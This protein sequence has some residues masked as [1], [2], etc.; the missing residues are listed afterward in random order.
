M[1]KLIIALL[2]VVSSPTSNSQT[3]KLGG[4]FDFMLGN[5]NLTHELG[6]D[7]NIEYLL[8][9]IP[10]SLSGCVRLHLS[11]LNDE[12]FK[13]SRG[14]T[15]NIYS[16]GI[17]VKYYPIRWDIE[18]YIGC[19]LFYNFN[20]SKASEMPYFIN[21]YLINPNIIGYNFSTEISGGLIFSA[22]NPI[23]FIFEITQSF[24]KPS[25]DLILL[26]SDN[27]KTIKKEQFNFNSFFIKL[28]VRFGL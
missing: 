17:V 11:E 2:L 9:G 6:P 14:Y 22:R 4:L 27:N 21:G 23:N 16:L 28:G 3:V 24:N 13:F 19:G 7:V 12:K 1:K 10:I 15:Y 25:Y 8:D 26:D 18:P 20:N 5:K